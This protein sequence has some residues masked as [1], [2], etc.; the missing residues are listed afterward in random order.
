[1]KSQLIN[2]QLTKVSYHHVKYLPYP[3][4]PILPHFPSQTEREGFG[5]IAVIDDHDLIVA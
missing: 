1:L 2:T 5:A 3:H 4:T